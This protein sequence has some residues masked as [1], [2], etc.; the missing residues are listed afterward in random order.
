MLDKI[1]Y[2]VYNIFS[3]IITAVFYILFLLIGPVIDS[4]HC[5]FFFLFQIE[6]ISLWISE[7]MYYL[8]LGKILLEFDQYLAVCI[9]STSV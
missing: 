9:F 2:V 5:P 4:F 7:Q 3:S 8:L 1:L 6:W